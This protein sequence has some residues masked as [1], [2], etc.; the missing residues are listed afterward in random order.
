MIKQIF[1]RLGRKKNT[2]K[3]LDD[4]T[5]LK[6]LP[7]IGKKFPGQDDSSIV[8]LHATPRPIAPKKK[9]S[10]EVFQ[11]AVDKLVD[12]LEGINNNLDAQIKQNEQLVQKMD[13]LPEMLTPL[14]KAV[15]E[16][17]AAF[18]Q[19]AEQLQNKVARDE[20][21]AEELIGIH[22]KVAESAQVDAKM[23]ENFG[24]FHETL[25]KLNADTVHQTEWIQHMGQAL[26]AN[27]RYVN[28]EMTKQQTRFYWV[29]GIS[30]GVS[31]LAIAG[32]IIGIILLRG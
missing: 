20:K 26:A 13:S 6:D 5:L 31:L 11:E 25:T 15:E 3:G 12:K 4:N 21:V 30:L 7:P 10:A 8:P 24:Q 27:E 23:C 9:D 17:R 28:R 2:T 32:M 29:C 16:Q 19:V 22:E 14:P 1:S 18:A